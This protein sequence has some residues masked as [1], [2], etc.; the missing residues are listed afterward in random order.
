MMAISIHVRVPQAKD[1]S[2]RATSPNHWWSWR[3]EAEGGGVAS[4]LN[5]QEGSREPRCPQPCSK[6]V[7]AGSVKGGSP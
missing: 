3:G 4:G 2:R 7:H 6:E 1:I 5:A